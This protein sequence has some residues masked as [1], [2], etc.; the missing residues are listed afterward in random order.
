MAQ[1]DPFAAVHKLN[2]VMV[3]GVSKCY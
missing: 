1:R 3:H 2:N